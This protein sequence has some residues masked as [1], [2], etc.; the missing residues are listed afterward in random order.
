[1][2]EEATLTAT[3]PDIVSADHVQVHVDEAAAAAVAT[4]DDVT[5]PTDDA[6]HAAIQSAAEAQQPVWNPATG[7][8]YYP[9]VAEHGETYLPTADYSINGV[10]SL[11]GAEHYVTGD[12]Y[13]GVAATL[14]N[15]AETTH[16]DDANSGLALVPPV[17]GDALAA[18]NGDLS[19][20][21]VID[22]PKKLVLACHFCRGRKLK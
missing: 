12:D 13:S 1:M 10:M 15:W 21:I 19:S 18:T 6:T 11:P 9:Q 5:A 7:Q 3:P 17:N 2:A 20:P 16:T 22:K 14:S 4:L 8:Y